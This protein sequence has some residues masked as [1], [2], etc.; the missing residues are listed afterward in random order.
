MNNLKPSI[1]LLPIIALIIVVG[2]YYFL[3]RKPSQSKFFNQFTFI[4][5]ILAFLLNFT[6]EVLQMPLYKAG[7]YNIESIAFCA[8]ASIAD[9]IMV[10]LLYYSFAVIYK[11]PI[12]VQ[13]LTVQRIAPLILVGGIGAILAEIG[14][15]S[16]GNW[17]YADTMPIIPVVNAGLSPV[18]QFMILPVLI[19]RMSLKIL[20]KKK[21]R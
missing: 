16:K 9:S 10:L 7:S 13:G 5:V 4:V 3:N 2:L 17:A 1:F 12:W 14:Y 21:G 20:N 18:L 8:L 19:Y 11:D 15:T 6:W